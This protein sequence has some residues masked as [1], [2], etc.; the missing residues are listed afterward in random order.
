M[1]FYNLFTFSLVA[2]CISYSQGTPL[3]PRVDPPFFVLNST[4]KIKFSCSADQIAYIKTAVTKA[5]Q[6]T[7]SAANIYSAPRM[8]QNPIVQAFL[9]QI[10]E[11]AFQAEVTKR[12]KTVAENLERK[13]S[14]ISA[15]DEEKIQEEDALSFFCQN[16]KTLLAVTSNQKDT[17]PAGENRI[18]LGKKFF[19]TETAEALFNKDK[20]IF[21][22]ANGDLTKWATALDNPGK[23]YLSSSHTLVHEAQH[24]LIL[25]GSTSANDNLK[26]LTN[27]AGKNNRPNACI[28]LASD[29][30]KQSNAE[31]W[32][33]LA[34]VAAV[35]P[36]GVR[37]CTPGTPSRRAV[38]KNKGTKGTTAPLSCPF[39]P[40]GKTAAATGKTATP[41]TSKTATNKA[42][43][44]T[45]KAT[46]GTA[47]AT[48]G[49]AKKTTG[50]AK[51]TTAGATAKTKATTAKK[52][53]VAKSKTTVPKKTTTAKKVTPVK[54]A[55][56]KVAV[57]KT[58]KRFDTSSGSMPMLVGKPEST[59]VTSKVIK[60]TQKLDKLI[61]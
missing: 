55:P 50:A 20:G 25:L 37:S 47:K 21:E 45:K 12:F 28:E 26:D 31:N 7:S 23:N 4:P 10:S 17:P 13:L 5:A 3:K 1:K 27:S 57:K 30:D 56:K 35:D 48:T 14:E 29:A 34:F 33:L 15:D 53:T 43:T 39:V 59:S 51:K 38:A 32:A 16:S 44:G 19:Q 40:K 61:M 6:I 2:T 60:S 36:D 46:T 52:S 42:A 58:P 18:V 24:S 8:S 49:T 41:V 22:T 9:G 54:T 11:V